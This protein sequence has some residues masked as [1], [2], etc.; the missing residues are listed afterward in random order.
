[1]SAGETGPPKPLFALR[2]FAYQGYALGHD[3]LWKI[4]DPG[5]PNYGIEELS[6]VLCSRL[7]SASLHDGLIRAGELSGHPS[8]CPEPEP[9][10]IRGLFQRVTEE[11]GL[12]WG[13]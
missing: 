2:S 1:M 6:L 8:A 11:H 13:R 4:M 5:P 7:F 3:A 9:E 10:A 12:V